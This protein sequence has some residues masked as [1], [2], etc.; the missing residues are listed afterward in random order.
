MLHKFVLYMRTN[1]TWFVFDCGKSL[2]IFVQF[3]D[4]LIYSHKIDF[5]AYNS[6][7]QHLKFS[8]KDVE[9]AVRIESSSKAF[10]LNADSAAKISIF[11]KSQSGF[12]QNI[13]V[14]RRHIFPG[15]GRIFVKNNI[16]APMQLIFYRPMF[17]HRIG[18]M[19]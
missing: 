8:K 9:E 3:S 16:Q 17:A 14:Q 7:Q 13:Q 6:G 11:A 12:A 4:L 2:Y 19:V 18:K 10:F 15:S 5:R 1:R